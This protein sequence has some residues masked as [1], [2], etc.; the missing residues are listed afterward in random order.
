[1]TKR[2]LLF[3][4]LVFA[5]GCSLNSQFVA[6][7]I[8]VYDAVGPRYV[9]YVEADTTLGSDDKATRLRTITEWKATLDEASK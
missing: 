7:E 3:F 4:A 9:K 2:L 5:S 8:A 1:M 6:G